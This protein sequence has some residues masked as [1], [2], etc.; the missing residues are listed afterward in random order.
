[1]LSEIWSWL[2]VSSPCLGSFFSMCRCLVLFVSRIKIL[3][4]IRKTF[5]DNLSFY[6]TKLFFNKTSLVA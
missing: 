2:N 3:D 4:S 1:M 5:E 6:H